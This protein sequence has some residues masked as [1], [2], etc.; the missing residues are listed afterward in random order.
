MKITEK[1][2][3]LSYG[4]QYIDQADIDAVSAVLQSDYLTTGP[5]V[6]AFEK[7][8]A[9]TVKEKYVVCVN[10]GTAALHLAVAG[11]DI[12][13][14]DWVIV[15]G[16]TFLAS[17]NVVRWCGAEVIFADVDKDNGLMQPVHLQQALE[18]NRD[19]NIKAIMP[20]HLTGQTENLAEICRIAR[21]NNL[22]VIEDACHAFGSE[23]IDGEPYYIGNC[24][25]SDAVA[26]SFHP[27]KTIA[28]GEGGAVVTRDKNLYD[29]ALQLR[30]HGMTRDPQTFLYQ[31]RALD[32]SG[33][34]NPW[35]YEMPRL[36]LN[37]RA[38]DINC[39]LG[40]SQLKKLPQFIQQ[41]RKLAN[42]YNEL[43]KP[44]SPKV[45]PIKKTS[46]CNPV[47]HLYS[48]LFDFPSIGMSRA[49]LMKALYEKGIGTQVHYIPVNEQ[50]YYQH[51]YQ[52]APLSGANAYYEKTLSL[53]L[54][55]AMQVEDVGYV[56]DSIKNILSKV[57]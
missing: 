22:L 20:V 57:Y 52:T 41:R 43:L 56:V 51:R 54:Y 24:Q 30:S 17:A 16:L 13:P 18:K 12:G 1:N 10:S 50:P 38:S 6:A 36:G 11:L 46:Y 26:F 31:N 33:A 2:K 23:Y 44:L 49:A 15:P 21:A 45:M 7:A 48:V 35:Y 25:H 40:L 19:K 3:F 55:P 5:T 42:I 4:R 27:V 14:G 29:A 34:V 32:V 9:D 53:P 39:A 8:I 37:Y 47:L 28:M